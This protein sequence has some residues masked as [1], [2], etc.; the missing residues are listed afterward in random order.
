MDEAEDYITEDS[1]E[2]P[3]FIKNGVHETLL[4]MSR[5][6]RPEDAFIILMSSA[7]S[8]S[9]YRGVTPEMLDDIFKDAL[10]RYKRDY[11]KFAD[12]RH[13]G[14]AAGGK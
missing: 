12:E 14:A 3:A 2:F 8:L 11:P 10:S 1:P 4:R 5:K 13:A 6:H 7:M 9:A